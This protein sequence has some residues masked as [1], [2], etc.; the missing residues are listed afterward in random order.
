MA[1]GGTPMLTGHVMA[2]RMTFLQ[3]LVWFDLIADYG[4]PQLFQTDYAKL[5]TLMS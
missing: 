3:G 2:Y 4:Q 1:R 5:L